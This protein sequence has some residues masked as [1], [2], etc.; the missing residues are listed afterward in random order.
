MRGRPHCDLVAQDHTHRKAY[1]GRQLGSQR[2]SHNITA[3]PTQSQP[4]CNIF[5]TSWRQHQSF[6]ISV[7]Y[8]LPTREDCSAISVDT[9]CDSSCTAQHTYC[10]ECA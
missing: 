3:V 10:Y 2:C 9:E 8:A 6:D 4:M 5:A 1:A 7:P